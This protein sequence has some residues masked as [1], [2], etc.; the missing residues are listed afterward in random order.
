MNLQWGGDRCN[1]RVQFGAISFVTIGQRQ[2]LE[3]WSGV[4]YL[5]KSDYGVV[6]KDFVEWPQV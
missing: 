5:V 2:M 6:L 4:K 3:L 1:I